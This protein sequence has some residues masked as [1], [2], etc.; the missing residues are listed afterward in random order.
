[1][2]KRA[3]IY[4]R[5]SGD[6]VREGKEGRNLAEQVKMGREYAEG[7]GY[8]IVAE[9]AEDDRGAS[10][11]SMDLEQLNRVF[12]MAQAGEYDI[13]IVREMDRLSR[14]LAKQLIIE[15]ELKRAGVEIEYVTPLQKR[16]DKTRPNCTLLKWRIL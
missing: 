15:E 16:L 11:A 10:G 7:K 8:S 13:L 2:N 5:V 4:A 1:M 9:L 14:R 6:D 12:S 3:I